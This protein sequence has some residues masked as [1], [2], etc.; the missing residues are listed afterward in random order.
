[1]EWP[2]AEGRRWCLKEARG[3]PG[4]LTHVSTVQA[5]LLTGCH[6]PSS[7]SLRKGMQL[8]HQVPAASL[9][10]SFPAPCCHLGPSTAV[11]LTW[12]PLLPLQITFEI[13]KQEDSQIP[14][15][16]IV[17]S[18]LGGLLLL[19]LLVLALWKVRAPSGWGWGAA[20]WL[21]R[22]GAPASEL[23]GQSPYSLPHGTGIHPASSP[24][25]ASHGGRLARATRGH[26]THGRSL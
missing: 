10:P 7:I 4:H 9:P 22:P 17:G 13:S 2:E 23:C 21:S 25:L 3:S 19:A 1:M 12:P 8:S 5:S 26:S 16:I 14:I 24:E 15:W 20:S 11:L 6:P 18:T